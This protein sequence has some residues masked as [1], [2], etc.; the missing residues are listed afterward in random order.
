MSSCQL[1]IIIVCYKNSS[2]TLECLKSIK[3]FAP[4]FAYET[5]C[6]DNASG[7]GIEESIVKDF[8]DVRFI[9]AG[10]NSGFSK[11]NNLGIINSRG[12]H[13]LLLNNDTKIVE[14]IFDQLI[15]FMSA[16]PKIGALGPRHLDGD[17]RFQISYGEFPTIMTEIKRQMMDRRILRNDPV[18]NRDLKEFCSK[19]REVDWLSGSCLLL[20]REALYQTGL[21]DEAIFMYL[22]DTDLCTRIRNKGWRVCYFPQVT[23]VHYQGGSAKGNVFTGRFEYRRSQIYFTRKYYGKVGEV[24]MR[25]FLFLKFLIIGLGRALELCFFK[26]INKDTQGVYGRM[27]FSFK[28]ISMV[29]LSKVARY[30]EPTLKV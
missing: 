21:L 15:G 26:I 24:F 16:H 14:P 23:I 8:P 30:V 10:Y 1:S 11:A 4:S 19:E 25:M 7:D 2:L 18:I 13:V 3:S 27:I 12:E 28:V 17:S 5:I 6:V 20:K 22:E 9:Q 29:L